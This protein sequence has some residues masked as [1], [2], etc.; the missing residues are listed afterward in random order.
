MYACCVASVRPWLVNLLKVT[1]N[2]VARS[3][4]F[5]SSYSCFL[6]KV[7]VSEQGSGIFIG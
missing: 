6:V 2:N 5:R 3:I 4:V 1:Q 7:G